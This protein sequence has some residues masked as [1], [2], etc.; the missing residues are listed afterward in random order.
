MTGKSEIGDRQPVVGEEQTWTLGS[1]LREAETAGMGP[2]PCSDT[3]TSQREDMLCSAREG[4]NNML[5]IIILLFWL[6][7]VAARVGCYLCHVS[8]RKALLAMDNS[9]ETT[10]GAGLPS[11][12]ELPAVKVAAKNILNSY[13]S[14][15]VESY[16]E[17]RKCLMV[18][19]L[20]TAQLLYLL[21]GD[22]AVSIIPTCLS[23][24]DIIHHS[25]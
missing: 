17:E 10:V 8:Y 14:V 6:S 19:I 22:C 15:A 25:L 12:P 24:T 13:D 16:R 11:L 3:G 23:D 5:T 2:S 9:L 4:C 21:A 20:P 18:I 7:P 1:A